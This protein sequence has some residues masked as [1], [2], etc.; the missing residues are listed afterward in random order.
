MKITK[1]VLLTGAEVVDAWRVVPR[2]LLFTVGVYVYWVTDWYM[3]L[4]TRGTTETVVTGIV[5]LV[6]PAVIN[7]YQTSG[8][9]WESK[10][11]VD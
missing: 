5:G 3:G 10:P 6:V 4:A 2:I 11:P 7:L 1:Q 8:R 9:T